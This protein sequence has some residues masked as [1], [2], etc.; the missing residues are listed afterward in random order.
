MAPR[1]AE[2][3]C[4]G[5]NQ[6]H[7]ESLSRCPSCNT[8]LVRL[9]V[10]TG[11]EL[12]GRELDGRFTVRERLGAGG[13][14]AVYKAWQHSVGREVALKVIAGRQASNP[15]AAKR[16]L[17]EA[18]LASRLAQPNIVSVVDFGQTPDGLLYLAMELCVGR[19][20][21][22]LIRD[23]GPFPLARVLRIA[24]QLCDALEAAHVTGI[25]HRDLKPQ[26][27]IVLDK[28]AGRDLLKVLDFGLARSLNGED[29]SI[30][31]SNVVG[32]PNYISPE[33]AMGQSVDARAD[34]YALGAIL[35]EMLTG[36]PPF[37]RDGGFTEVV[38]RQL[39][40]SPPALPTVP[41][42]L[43]ALIHRCLSVRP[44]ERPDSAATLHAQL[45]TFVGGDTA[46]VT[47]EPVPAPEPPRPPPRRW[48]ASVDLA[49]AGF[50]GLGLVVAAATVLVL[51]AREPSAAPVAAPAPAPVP[52]P[53]ASAVEPEPTPAP[54][55]PS[56]PPPLAAEP[57]FPSRKEAP[58]RTVKKGA[59]KPEPAPP[60]EPVAAPAPAP[61]PAPA[62]CAPP[63]A[64]WEECKAGTCVERL[65]R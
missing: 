58:R 39:T 48:W 28:P 14:G 9:A 44:D 7:P 2:H 64:E 62:A 5:C 63:C 11:D 47:P 43:E 18:R 34:L 60:V 54:A 32:S 37:G 35:V 65:M 31:G 24:L 4:P 61:A 27:I 19:T 45:G 21:S 6:S 12:I 57:A 40:L 42:S 22:K 49:V 50:V 52:A 20:L 8:A 25:V 33:E 15:T 51:N 46:A 56:A 10:V 29:S 13:M 36:S 17:R 3:Y 1:A 55:A 53:A 38:R 30:T 41:A 23:E 59:P 16:F 26:N